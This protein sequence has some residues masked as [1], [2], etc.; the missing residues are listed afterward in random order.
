MIAG[1]AWHERLFLLL[2]SGVALAAAL[3]L[4]PAGLTLS[5]CF[6]VLSYGIMLAL[7]RRGSRVRLLSNY[8][9]AWA[10]YAGSS[11]V[12][13]SL[14]IP[15]WHKELLGLDAI[16]FGQS[17]ALTWQG[18]CRPWMYEVLSL[19]YLSYHVYLHWALLDAL[20]RDDS[21]RSQIS[22]RLF[23]AFAV[24]L[25]G[26]L[27]AP[28]APPSA[29]FPELF[30]LPLQGGFL[31]GW[32][33]QVNATL[34]AKY[35]AFPSLHVLITLTLLAW[36]WS[37]FRKRFWTMLLPSMLML[38]ATLVLRLHYAVDLLA[39]LA[40]FMIILLCHARPPLRRSMGS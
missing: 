34:A 5:V 20:W 33:E 19:G 15:L 18:I 16:L 2:G 3:K 6:M 7:T 1:W 11:H 37:R 38:A 17:P 26:Y 10:F 14:G 12:V 40:L 31:T 36:D 22:T 35:D 4:G 28:A 27:L 39:S 24:G 25:T 13:T 8:L 30:H 29:A 9:A 23:T 21:W 32:N